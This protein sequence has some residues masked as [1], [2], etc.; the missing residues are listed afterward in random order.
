MEINIILTSVDIF[1][2]LSF[3]HFIVCQPWASP[4]W[5][6]LML[7]QYANYF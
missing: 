4:Q 6:I 3:K 5:A 7:I 1:D 2:F